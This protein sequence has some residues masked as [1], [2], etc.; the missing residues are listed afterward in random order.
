MIKIM[1]EESFSK[2]FIEEIKNNEEIWSFPLSE[3]DYLLKE[4]K[5]ECFLLIKDRLYE[6]NIK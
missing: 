4:H 3:L 2:E 6:F 1:S 5:E